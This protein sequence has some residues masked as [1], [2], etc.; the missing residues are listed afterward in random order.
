VVSIGMVDG[1]WHFL[2]FRGEYRVLSAR[3]LSSKTE[4]LALIGGDTDWLERCFARHATRKIGNE[5]K[6]VPAGVSVPAAVAWLIRQ[7]AGQPMPGD[8]LAVR[9]T[10][11]WLFDDGKPVAHCG[12]V[13]WHNGKLTPAGLRTLTAIY[14]ADPPASRPGEP[15][16]PEIVKHIQ[17]TAQRLWRERT[18]GGIIMLLGAVGS[19]LLGAVPRSRSC[20]FI[21]G[22]VG[23]G[24]SMPLDLARA[25]CPMHCYTS[26]TT[27]A[28][29]EAAINGHAMPSLIDEASDQEDQRGA[30]NLLALITASTGGEG[31][32]ITR[33]TG[34]G[35]GRSAARNSAS[36][37]IHSAALRGGVG[38]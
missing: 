27:K 11:V 38:P 31:A 10:G 22:D 17:I 1:V 37:M 16:G 28:G 33:G 13:L 35:K 19:A 9:H 25:M 12:D 7:C 36:V 5:Y 34:D 20:I 2:D 21:G 30:Q 29:L 14:A 15:C 24:K 6:T 3:Q 23:G 8:D 4:L 32:K 26:D 18:A